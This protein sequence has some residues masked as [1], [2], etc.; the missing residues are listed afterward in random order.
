[1]FL[2]EGRGLRV[3]SGQGLTD[4]GFPGMGEKLTNLCLALNCGKEGKLTFLI[5]NLLENP[6]IPKDAKP[7]FISFSKPIRQTKLFSYVY[8]N[9]KAFLSSS[10]S[11]QLLFVIGVKLYIDIPL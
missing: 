9:P 7:F 3:V 5:N 6:H 2:L 4:K 8:F 11:F 10:E 1:M